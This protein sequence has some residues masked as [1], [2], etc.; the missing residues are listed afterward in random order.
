MDSQLDID[1]LSPASLLRNDVRDGVSD[2][3]FPATCVDWSDT[4]DV[5]C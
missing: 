2:I 1:L 3:V 4:D 5:S